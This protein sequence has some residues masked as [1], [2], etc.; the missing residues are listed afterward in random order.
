MAANDIYKV[1]H[2]LGNVYFRKS[3][4]Q[5]AIENYKKAVALNTQDYKVYYDMASAYA[6]LKDYPQA[7]I[8]YKKALSLKKEDLYTMN[9]LAVAYLS[10]GELDLARELAEIILEKD[11]R[12]ANKIFEQIDNQK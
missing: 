4:F 7:I 9:G 11:K 2:D 8:N 6:S 1:H 10:E 12:L 3:D 5:K